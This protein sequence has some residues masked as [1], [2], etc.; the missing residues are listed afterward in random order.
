MNKLKNTGLVS[1]GPRRLPCWS[2]G[3]WLLEMARA[4]CLVCGVKQVFWKSGRGELVIWCVNCEWSSQFIHRWDCWKLCGW[5]LWL[6]PLK[7]EH[8]C[9]NFEII[10]CLAESSFVA[11]HTHAMRW[12]LAWGNIMLRQE[13]WIKS[14]KHSLC[15][16]S[17]WNDTSL[18]RK[19][20]AWTN[21]TTAYN[22]LDLYKW[23]YLYVYLPQLMQIWI[24]YLV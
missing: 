14:H 3:A 4:L 24:S 12:P 23:F 22:R 16:E 2:G 10:S 1:D 6:K 13:D 21:W 15:K 18:H 9:I 7:C 5:I 20:K 8:V 11:A 19:P 17:T